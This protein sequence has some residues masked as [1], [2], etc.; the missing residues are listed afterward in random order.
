MRKYGAQILPLHWCIHISQGVRDIFVCHL[1]MLYTW[2]DL[3]G[4]DFIIV[5]NVLSA[6]LPLIHD[7]RHVVWKLSGILYQLIIDCEFWLSA[8]ALVV[9]SSRQTLSLWDCKLSMLEVGYLPSHD[10]CWLLSDRTHPQMD[11]L[12]LFRHWCYHC[13]GSWPTFHPPEWL[14]AIR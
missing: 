11:H 13:R 1:P 3:E 12:H 14:Y 4:R 6:S 5:W 9:D 10:D 8:C 7:N 2:I